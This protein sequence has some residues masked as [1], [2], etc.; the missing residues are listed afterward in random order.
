MRKTKTPR[1]SPIITD[2][3]KPY[4]FKSVIISEICGVFVFDAY[5]A[6]PPVALVE[7]RQIRLV[8]MPVCA[9]SRRNQSRNAG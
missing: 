9:A 4:F 5:I 1:I 6:G 3:L 7:L 8:S 2:V